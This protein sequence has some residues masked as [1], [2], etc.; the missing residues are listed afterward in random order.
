MGRNDEDQEG[1]IESIDDLYEIICEDGN[2]FMV[3]EP[4]Y[5]ELL[6]TPMGV[7]ISIKLLSG[8]W[9]TLMPGKVIAFTH[10]TKATREEQREIDAM[11][12]DEGL[13]W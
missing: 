7:P 5:M 13:V 6:Q 3:A 9:I 2:I 12:G 8:S 1:S 4:T 10:S 11:I